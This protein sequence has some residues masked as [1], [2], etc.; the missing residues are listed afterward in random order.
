MRRLI[1]TCVAFAILA[2]LDIGIPLNMLVSRAAILKHGTEVKLEL[3]TRDPRDLF[4]GEYSQLAYAIGS[5]ANVPAPDEERARCA[6][7]SQ[8]CTAQ[9]GQPLFVMLTPTDNGTYQA[10]QA[11][12]TEPAAGVLFVRGKI[13]YGS[14]QTNIDP[15]RCP[16]GRCFSGQVTYGIES[17]FG[18]Q[19]VPAQVDRVAR[20]KILAVVRIDRTGTAV[21]A[22]LLLDRK[23][24]G[25]R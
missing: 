24:V 14:Y 2:A 12:L 7:A 23:P 22:D 9:N 19:G 25:V 21:L 8:G 18:P 15:E 11:S 6:A 3:T 4:R 1:L 5:L 16:S 13:S 17:W 20:N 10:S